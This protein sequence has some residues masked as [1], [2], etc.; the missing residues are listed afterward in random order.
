MMA[1]SVADAL[2]KRCDYQQLTFIGLV[3]YIL[4]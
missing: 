2:K 3:N 4:L 1:H